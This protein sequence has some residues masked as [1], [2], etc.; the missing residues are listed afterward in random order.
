M[1]PGTTSSARHRGIV[2]YDPR[3]GRMT[4]GQ[5]RAWERWWP[6]Y[7]RDVDGLSASLDAVEWFGRDAPLVLEIGSGMGESTVAMAAAEPQVSHLAVEVY[8]P[9][10]AHLL[11]RIRDT[12]VTN[13]RLLRGD[14]VPVLRE[15]IEADSLA[16]IRVFFPDPWPKQRHQKRR[17]VQPGFVRL[18][19]TRL[20]PDGT[21]HLATD[22][23]DYATQMREVCAAEPLLR[24]AGGGSGI[25]PRPPWR[26]VTKFEQRAQAEGRTVTDL[27]YRRS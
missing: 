22:W 17:L 18:A 12:G 4:A 16:G 14:A 27:L 24:P 19:A 25:V 21:L 6:T 20:V 23:A 9:G 10:L 5:R 13:L 1:I 2:S 26:P 7:G 3:G 8:Q 15:L 11:I